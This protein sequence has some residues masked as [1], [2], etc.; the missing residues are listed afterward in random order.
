MFNV[1]LEKAEYGVGSDTLNAAL[2][3]WAREGR[4]VFITNVSRTDTFR[5]CAQRYYWD[6]VHAG[7]GVVRRDAQLQ[8]ALEI[9]SAIHLA[10]ELLL[11]EK[12]G[13][14]S[15]NTIPAI[16]SAALEAM[17]R[18]GVLVEGGDV[19]PKTMEKY[20]AFSG[21]IESLIKA[22][23]PR[24]DCIDEVWATEKMI[25]ACV[26]IGGTGAPWIC[27]V[28][29]PDAIIVEQDMVWHLQHKS[30]EKESEYDSFST[31]LSFGAHETVY[32]WI[33]SETI[34]RGMWGED[35]KKMRYGG[36]KL[37]V[38]LK[39]AR[40]DAKIT[41]LQKTLLDAADA[42][43]IAFND[44][45]GSGVL[46]VTRLDCTD[47]QFVNFAKMAVKW[48]ER[49]SK[50]IEAL[51][52]Y[53]D[54]ALQIV[55]V[56]LD[57][58]KMEIGF[59]RQLTAAEGQREVGYLVEPSMELP[60]NTNACDRWNRDCPHLESTT[61]GGWDGKDPFMPYG[62]WVQRE[63]DYVDDFRT[64]YQTHLEG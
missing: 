64:W 3:L 9:G 49:E 43:K 48:N 17:L 7:N 61:C 52:S 44:F 31:K 45:A 4:S 16:T 57:I 11:K 26:R 51:R 63:H 20:E 8:P 36:S 5:D 15:C 54:R 59:R 34:K 10:A 41:T 46:Q 33:M 37:A 47:L 25:W 50:R 28:G 1:N 38:W 58:K 53:D 23:A 2:A 32:G 24:L 27:V 42:G 14:F 13:G 55:D 6:H 21:Y 60:G 35:R 19:P 40:P 18:A 12:M 29:R 62:D 56:D 30:R 22:A 39:Q